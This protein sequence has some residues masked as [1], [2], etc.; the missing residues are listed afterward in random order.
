MNIKALAG[1]GAALALTVTM[2]ATP[3]FAKDGEV[4]HQGSCSGK[5]DWKLKAAPD[6]G[7]FEVEGEVDSNKV[8]QKWRW[9]MKHNGSLSDRGRATTTAPSGSFDVERLMSDLKGA[10]TFVFR[11]KNRKTGEVCRGTVQI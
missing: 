7:G 6:D 8:G 11:A 3:A 5:S 1:A 4:I 9:R 2:T 10:D